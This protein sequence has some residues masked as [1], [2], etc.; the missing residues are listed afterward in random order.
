MTALA[1]NHVTVAVLAGYRE[2]AAV[3]GR[4]ANLA[5]SELK[6]STSDHG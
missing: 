6:P 2:Q 1:S 5:R 4:N 3:I